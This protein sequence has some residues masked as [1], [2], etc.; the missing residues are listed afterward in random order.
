MKKILLLLYFP[1]PFFSSFAHDSQE[2]DRDK[3]KSLIAADARKNGFDSTVAAEAFD[4]FLN[5]FNVKR[6]ELTLTRTGMNHYNV[7]SKTLVINGRDSVDLFGKVLGEIAHAV[8]FNHR[9][10]YYGLNAGVTFAKTFFKAVFSANKQRYRHKIDSVFKKSSGRCSRI[11]AA[12]IGVYLID[13]YTDPA[14]FEFEHHYLDRALRVFFLDLMTVLP[15]LPRKDLNDWIKMRK[16]QLY[17]DLRYW[18]RFSFYPYKVHCH[19]EENDS[20]ENIC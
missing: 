18:R 12:F 6:V 7:F 20:R 13:A 4:I 19:H 15:C 16:K 3:V 8:Q 1:L 11:R 14:S 10:M 17:K 2:D 9:P 5:T